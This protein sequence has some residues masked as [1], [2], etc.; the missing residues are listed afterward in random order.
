MGS[1]ELFIDSSILEFIYQLIKPKM[2]T[3]LNLNLRF[4]MTLNLFVVQQE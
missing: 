2:I 4:P 1:K 3:H